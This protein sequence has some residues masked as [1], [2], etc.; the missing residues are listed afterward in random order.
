MNGRDIPKQDFFLLSVRLNL[1]KPAHT[2]NFLWTKNQYITRNDDY[3]IIMGL[4]IKK[5]SIIKTE[6]N[7]KQNNVNGSRKY[8]LYIYIDIKITLEKKKKLT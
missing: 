5:N 7:R 2:T 4:I 3:I 6:P 8:I 1:F